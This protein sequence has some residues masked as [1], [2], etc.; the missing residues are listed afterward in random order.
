MLSVLGWRPNHPYH[1]THTYT[2][3]PNEVPVPPSYAITTTGY[4]DKAVLGHWGGGVWVCS[5]ETYRYATA[6]AAITN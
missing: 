5:A 1:C 4:L 2:E 3:V 6:N